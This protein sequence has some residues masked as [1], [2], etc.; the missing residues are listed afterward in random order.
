METVLLRHTRL[1]DGVSAEISE[2][3]VLVSDGKIAE[4]GEPRIK[5]KTAKVIDVAGRTLMPGL[6]DAHIH[7][8]FPDV[9]PLKTERM[10]MTLVAHR[11]RMMLEKSL[12]R[13]F[14]SVRDAGGGDYGLH[15]AVEKGW[16]KGPRVFYCG[17]ALSQTGG[18]GDM[19]RGYEHELCACESGPKGHLS[20]VVDGVD[21]LRFAVRSEMRR[22][23]HFI[24]IMGSGGVASTVDPVHCA[25]Y[26][27]EEIAAV[28][29]EV[30]RHD[31][32]VTAHCHPD[33]AIR[34][35]IE[36]G[37]H[38]I[39]HGTLISDET[40]ALAAKKGTSIVPTLAVVNSLSLH[41]KSLGFPPES[42]KKLRMIAPVYAANVERMKRAGVRIGW[43][44]D[45]IGELDRDQCTEFELR[46][47]IFSPVE[48]L[49]QA[50]S[51]NAE[52][53]RQSSRLGKVAP[54]FEA[55][56]IVVDGDPLKDV[57][58][59]TE[60]GRNVPLVMKAGEIM[61]MAL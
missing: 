53:M 56:L 14:T 11:A 29:D 57:A 15:L 39:E 19:R 34:R 43:G 13:G 22:G 51:I 1:F 5:T 49:R 32:Y 47:E 33:I 18:H 12:K 60:D 9:D 37:V 4:I 38:C 45:L 25:Q 16:I 10:P 31:S 35:C 44:T 8:Y 61:K 27:A 23:A 42:L 58:L 52:I 26:S 20:W 7:A 46:R 36:L 2:A 54:G 59:F 55:D 40:A 50:T 6:I 48:I 41:G 21:N 30:E 28:V 3:D 24:K 17:K